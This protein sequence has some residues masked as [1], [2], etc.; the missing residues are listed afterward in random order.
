MVV[1]VPRYLVKAECFHTEMDDLHV[2]V[3]VRVHDSH[4]KSLCGHGKLLGRSV[5]APYLVSNTSGVW[6]N[7]GEDGK[8]RRVAARSPQQC[9]FS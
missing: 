8:R 1:P 3:L 9:G 6:G 7:D 5:P 2:E 4:G